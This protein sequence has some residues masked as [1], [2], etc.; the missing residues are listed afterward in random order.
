MTDQQIIAELDN[1][2]T[3]EELRKNGKL[4][5][6]VINRIRSIRHTDQEELVRAVER[7]RESLKW[8]KEKVCTHWQDNC[9]CRSDE[10]VETH[11]KVV[12]NVFDAVLS[13]LAKR[14]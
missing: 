4:Y 7:K 2:F 13:L 8:Q 5:G 6:A 3:F 12:D 10:E 11:N 9:S 14:E 1:D